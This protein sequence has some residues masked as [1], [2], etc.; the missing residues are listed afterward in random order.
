M[1]CGKIIRLVINIGSPNLQAH[2]A[3]ASLDLVDHEVCAH[4][5]TIPVERTDQHGPHDNSAS[6]A[7]QLVVALRA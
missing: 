5:V 4:F 3:N 7:G 1:G 2:C 6:S